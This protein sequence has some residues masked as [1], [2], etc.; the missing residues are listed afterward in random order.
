MLLKKYW[1]HQHFLTEENGQPW[2]YKV[3]AFPVLFL[4]VKTK[5]HTI[6][7]LSWVGR[8]NL[9]PP[10]VVYTRRRSDFSI[11]NFSIFRFSIFWFSIFNF[12]IYRFWIFQFSIFQFSIFN[13]SILDFSIHWFFDSSIFDFSIFD[14][15]IFRFFYFSIFD[16]R[17]FYFS[18]FRKKTYVLKSQNRKRIPASFSRWKAPRPLIV[19][20]VLKG[21]LRKKPWFDAV[22]VLRTSSALLPHFFLMPQD[23]SFRA[24]V[25]LCFFLIFIIIF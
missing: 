25:F 18:I 13:F 7:K 20:V 11:F 15:S 6:P 9:P 2:K 1:Q 10:L 22:F 14:F 17:F 5:D 4:F 3:V 19:N 21:S 8:G 12:S 24:P 23:V 16:F